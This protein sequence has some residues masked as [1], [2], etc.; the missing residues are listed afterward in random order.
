M[1]QFM[2]D[3]G[4]KFLRIDENIDERRDPLLSTRAAARLLKQNYRLFESWPLAVT[5]YNH[6]TEGIFRGMKA[7]ESEDLGDLIQHYQSPTFGFASKNFYAEFL[8][9]SEITRRPQ[10][11]FP[12]LRAHPPLQ[13]REVEVK[14]QSPLQA[15]LKPA[16]I[17]HS[18]FFDWNPALDEDLKVLPLGYR[19]KLPA[20]KLAAYTLAERRAWEAAAKKIKAVRVTAK[21]SRGA[22]APAKTSAQRQAGVAGKSAPSQKSRPSMSVASGSSSR[23]K[24]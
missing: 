12:S 18:E 5:A 14:R 20:H 7:T 1:W 2:P 3:T 13:L 9:V 22:Q 11:Y 15:V 8:A 6:G 21:P 17:A 4:R 23:T 19:I 10:V 24:L 16:A